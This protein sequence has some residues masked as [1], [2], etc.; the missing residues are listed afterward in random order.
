MEAAWQDLRPFPPERV[1]PALG[2]RGA[3]QRAELLLAICAAPLL[4]PGFWLLAPFPHL[5]VLGADGVPGVPGVSLQ[6]SP[7]APCTADESN[8]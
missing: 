8:F 6:L 2:P 5:S 4:T 7:A 3:S 1:E